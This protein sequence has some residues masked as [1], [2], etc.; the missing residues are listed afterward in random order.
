MSGYRKFESHLEAFDLPCRIGIVNSRF[1]ARITQRLLDS[2]LEELASAGVP[3]ENIWVVNVP[4][5]FEIP[6]ATKQLV[7]SHNLD[8]VIALGAIIRGET[9]HFEHVC[10]E[11]SHGIAQLSLHSMIPVIFGVLTTD[12]PEQALARTEPGENNKGT[13]AAQS[14]LEMISLMRQIGETKPVTDV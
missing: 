7:S 12:T 9:A 3:S 4:G 2:C 10:R 8:A 13:E 1:N 5:S 11:C 14:A 6:L